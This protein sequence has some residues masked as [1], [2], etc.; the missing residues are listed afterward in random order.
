MYY[1]IA[2]RNGKFKLVLEKFCG[3]Y[4]NVFLG[5]TDCAKKD[6]P[7]QQVHRHPLHIWTVIKSGF[8]A[9]F[10]CNYRNYCE[11]DLR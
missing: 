4:N 2:L 10:L 11:R 3:V 6:M 1:M 7:I 9:C 5:M 8:S